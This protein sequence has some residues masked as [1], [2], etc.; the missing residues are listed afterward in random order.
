MEH[1]N[2]QIN[3]KVKAAI[4]HEVHFQYAM[5]GALWYTTASD[6]LFPVPFE[7]VTGGVFNRTERGIRL[8]KWIRKFYHSL[9]HGKHQAEELNLDAATPEPKTLPIMVR[10]E[11]NDEG[12]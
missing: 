3:L 9:E 11:G 1:I 2:Q 7:D 5:D 4:K 6:D 10:S 12:C 8:M